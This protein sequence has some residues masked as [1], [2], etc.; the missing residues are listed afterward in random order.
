MYGGSGYLDPPYE[1]DEYTLPPTCQRDLLQEPVYGGSRYL[2]PPYETDE[3]EVATVVEPQSRL[4][5]LVH[6][7]CLEQHVQ[8]L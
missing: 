2:D 4:T 6:L 1:T 7:V 3:P 8:H 5:L